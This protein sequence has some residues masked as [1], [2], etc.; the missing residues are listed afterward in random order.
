MDPEFRLVREDAKGVTRIFYHDGE[1]KTHVGDVRFDTGEFVPCCDLEEP[2][3]VVLATR[4][5]L[6]KVTDSLDDYI[7]SSGLLLV[8]IFVL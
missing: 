2:E 7:A 4:A 8:S 1:K 6:T 5:L 3:K